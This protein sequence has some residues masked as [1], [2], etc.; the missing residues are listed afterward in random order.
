MID[1][2]MAEDNLDELQKKLDEYKSRYD[3]RG[4]G[5]TIFQPQQHGQKWVARI[6]RSE[7]CA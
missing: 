4:Y 3:P 6:V 5:T 1:F 7:S 2:E